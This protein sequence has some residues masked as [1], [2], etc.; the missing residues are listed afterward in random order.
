MD[1][2]NLR[3]LTLPMGASNP[4][5]MLHLMSKL[6]VLP[7]RLSYKTPPN[8]GFIVPMPECIFSSFLSGPWPGSQELRHRGHGGSRIMGMCAPGCWAPFFPLDF[9]S[10]LGV[11]AHTYNPSSKE[12]E[13]GRSLGLPGASLA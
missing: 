10:T 12:A 1:I 13:T 9:R 11:V 3:L 5:P 8:P 6:K 4:S 2:Y 7:G